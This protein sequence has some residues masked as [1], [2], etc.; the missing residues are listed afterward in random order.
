MKKI[1]QIVI[2][3]FAGIGLVL[4]LG[5]LAIRLHLTNSRGIIEG[6]QSRYLKVMTVPATST[7][8]VEVAGTTELKWSLAPEWQTF[9]SAVNKDQTPLLKVQKETGVTARL[10]MAL[11]AAEQLRLY[12]DNREVYKQIFEPLKILGSQSQYSWGIL[13]IKEATAE[14]IENNLK[15]RSSPFYP[16]V[17]YSSL[18][19]FKTSEVG[20]E[21]FNRIID[22]HDHYYSYLYAALYIKGIE[23]QWKKAGFNI[24]NNIGV[25]ATL[26]NIG[27]EHSKPNPTPQVGGA[28]IPIGEKTYSFGGLVYNIYYSNELLEIFPRE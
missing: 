5:Y 19:N 8:A 11:T 9:K 21:R 1:F 2:Y 25:L 18:L 28:A 23:T 16:G 26:Y 7:A 20:T 13:G 10:I 24:S 6:D 12:Y 14:K 22:E 27:F 17:E 3:A 15:E 4:T